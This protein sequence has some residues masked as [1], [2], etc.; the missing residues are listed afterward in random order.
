MVTPTVRRQ[1]SDG[2]RLAF[3]TV[4]GYFVAA[5]HATAPPQSCDTSVHVA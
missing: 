2:A 3:V 4:A 5:H 1:V